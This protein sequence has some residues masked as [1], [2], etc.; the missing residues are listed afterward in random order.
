MHP[1]ALLDACA[2]LVRLTLKFDNSADATVQRFFRDNKGLGPRE[3]A[4]IAET[5]YTVLRKK[6]LFDHFA[7]SGSGS[8]ERRLAIQGFYGPRDFLMSALTDTEKNWLE[9]CDKVVVADLMERHRH[10]L[11]D[12]LVQPLKEQLAG[13]LNAPLSVPLSEGFWPLVESLNLGAGL[14][15]RVNA[16]NAKRA[17]V[18]KEL[19]KAGIKALPTP[20]SPW[21]LRIAGKPNLNKLESFTRGDF[22][23]Q[24]EGSQLLV[25]LLDAKRGEMVVDFCAGAGGKTLAIGAGMRSTGR[26]YAFDT[27]AHRLDALKPRLKRSGLSNVHPAAIAHERD[28]RV[29]RLAGKIDRV[30]VDA[31]CSGLGTLRRNPDLKWRQNMQVVEQMAVRQAAILH[32]AARLVKPGGRLVYATCS[33]L[34]QENEAIA[35]AFTDANS[36]FA[37]LE[38]GEV[39]YHLKV[40]GAAILCSG[41]ENGQKY[42]RL[43]PHRH[44]TDGFFAAVWQKK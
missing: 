37:P 44:G 22:E 23:V 27:S 5:V 26:L 40:E 6:L 32:S 41:G 9:Q 24:D 39:L 14:D 33:F 10:N 35:Q 13:P 16:L 29:K 34:P 11:P 43:W 7:P 20:Y 1:K 25:M 42:L 38:A 18:Q 3:R 28:D 30:L 19:A 31:P 2:E 17:D 4:T 8:R 21:G 15:L 36:E 12:W